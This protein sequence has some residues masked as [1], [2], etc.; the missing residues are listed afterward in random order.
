VRFRTLLD[1]HNPVF[2]T[3]K[4]NIAPAGQVRL[5]WN[6]IPPET[7]GW[8][9]NLT[10]RQVAPLLPKLS[11]AVNRPSDIPAPHIPGASQQAFAPMDGLDR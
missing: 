8:R 10:R 2:Q 3:T 7:V 6:A 9:H 1:L 4:R 5:E 11:R